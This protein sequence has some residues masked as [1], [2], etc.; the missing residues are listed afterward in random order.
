MAISS[1]I[2]DFSPDFIFIWFKIFCCYF[3][4]FFT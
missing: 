3:W 1:L 2:I 4:N